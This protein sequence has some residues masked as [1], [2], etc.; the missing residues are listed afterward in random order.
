M[1]Q[2]GAGSHP[3]TEGAHP[4]RRSHDKA[5]GSP[6]ERRSRGFVVILLVLLS[7]GCATTRSP[8][9]AADYSTAAELLQIVS[10]RYDSLRTLQTHA[11][12]TFKL[13]GIRESRATTRLL[14]VSPHR[15]RIDV[16]TFGISIMTAVA[17]GNALEV[18]LPRENNS[19]VGQPEKVL[20]ALTGVDLAYYN[21]DHA[22]LGLPNLSLLDLPRVIGFS[23]GQSQVF[24]EIAYPLWKRKLVFDRRSATLLE[25]HVFDFE[26]HLIS[27]R[28]LSGYY[29]ASGFA[30]P[31]HI[32]IFQ[33]N[34]LIAID[35]KSHQINK[36]I[37]DTD[38]QMRVPG[39]VT[40]HQIE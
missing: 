18:Y 25:D 12:I 7:S 23:A 8:R 36:A 15:L 22:V 17:D 27:K 4:T 38:F 14:Y 26:G 31:K 37:S 34:D 11:N 13:D 1:G 19:L 28:L 3:G 2:P 40:R 20:H 6:L 32:A 9:S 10:S 29:S 5:P 33:G 30:L 21:L 16:G 39:D 35:V 24:V